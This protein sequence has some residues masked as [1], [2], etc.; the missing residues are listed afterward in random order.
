MIVKL[1][2]E[3]HLEFLGLKGDCRGLSKSTLVKMSSYWKSHVAD[4]IIA[5][6]NLSMFYDYQKYNIYTYTFLK[7]LYPFKSA[8]FICHK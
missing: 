3:H 5:Q 8:F 1:L 4:Q 6:G 2:T 7:E